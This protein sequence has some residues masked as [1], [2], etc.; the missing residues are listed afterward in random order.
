MKEIAQ[1]LLFDRDGRLLIYLRD[2]KPEIPFP[3]HWDFF[4]GHIEEG[5]TPE[6]ALVREVGE[7]L[8]VRLESWQFFR[9]YECLSGDV[10]PNIK[11]IFHARID[12]LASELTL[13]EGQRIASIGSDERCEFRFA[14]ILA[15]ILTDFVGSGLWSHPVDNSFRDIAAK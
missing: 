15:T 14:N 2:N 7:E 8:G 5:E 1:V 4:G 13:Y 3:D 10:Y 11:H 9:R 12:R 6:Q